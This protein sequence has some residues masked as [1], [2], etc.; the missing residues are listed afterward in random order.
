MNREPDPEDLSAVISEG[1]L[2][3][4]LLSLA[5]LDR[6]RTPGTGTGDEAVARPPFG[7]LHRPGAWPAGTRPTDHNTC[8]PNCDCALT[9]RPPE[10]DR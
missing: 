6:K 10:E 8:H 3:P 4:Y 7:P 5:G 9:R 2:V 1:D